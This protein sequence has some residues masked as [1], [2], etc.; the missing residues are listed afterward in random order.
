MAITGS[1]INN[2]C[3]TVS[4]D[5]VV[6][7]FFIKNIHVVFSAGA[8]GNSARIANGTNSTIAHFIANA[9]NYSGEW[10]VMKTVKD[11]ELAAVSGDAEVY[12]DVE[13]G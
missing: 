5:S 2:F 11:F 12:V 8:A 10:A 3:L 1:S 6:G 9:A 4:G 7:T 13:K